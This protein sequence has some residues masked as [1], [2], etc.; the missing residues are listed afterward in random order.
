LADARLETLASILIDYSLDV[1][2]GQLVTVSGSPLAA[3]LIRAVYRQILRRGGHPLPQLSLPGIAEIFYGQATD[4]QLTYIRPDGRLMPEPADAALSILSDADTKAL[5][6]IDPARQRMARQA[7]ADLTQRYLER[8]A[9][10][11][12]KW[13]VTLFP[14]EVF[15]EDAE[16]SLV[17]YEE[18]VYDAGLLDSADSVAEW[19]GVSREQQRLIE[20]LSVRSVHVVA[21][22]TDL[23]LEIAGRTF[24]NGDGRYNFPDGE[25]FTLS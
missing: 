14:T 8:S 17:D 7:R 12:L 1:Q 6:G 21:P 19:R 23:T 4:E 25:I 24:I 5:S 22:G 13:C 15:A 10:G 20:W 16:M 3:P 11:T 9:A 18:F 2:S